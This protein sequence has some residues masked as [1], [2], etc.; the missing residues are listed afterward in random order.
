[1]KI[2]TQKVAFVILCGIYLFAVISFGLELRAQTSGK[3]Q[4]HLTPEEELAMSSDTTNS[5]I[6]YIVYND[7]YT[8]SLETIES[9][10]L[11]GGKLEV[12][13]HA[14]HIGCLVYN[15]K[16]KY[17]YY[18]KDIYGA[19]GGEIKLIR[20]IEADIIPTQPEQIKWP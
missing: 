20:T 13:R 7:Y 8:P 1:M 16:Q 12:I 5:D 9:V 15:C 6:S 2:I 17:E 19:V 14:P 11:K 4:L 3:Q 10:I 18:V